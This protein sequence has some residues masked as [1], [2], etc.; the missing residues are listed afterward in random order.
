GSD[1]PHSLA[2]RCGIAIDSVGSSGPPKDI[3]CCFE[4]LVDRGVVR[5]TED[6][7]QLRHAASSAPVVARKELEAGR[8]L[9]E[10]CR[11]RTKAQLYRSLNALGEA[12]QVPFV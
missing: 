12:R 7:K 2:R 8:M 9:C 1:F 11:V 5:C 6:R 4:H 3:R 10:N